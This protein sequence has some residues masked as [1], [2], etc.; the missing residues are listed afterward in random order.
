MEQLFFANV[1]DNT[2]ISAGSTWPDLRLVRDNISEK[3]EGIE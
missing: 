1:P 3:E 2:R